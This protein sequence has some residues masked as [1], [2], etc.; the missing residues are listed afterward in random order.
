MSRMAILRRT[1]AR[2]FMASH[3]CT[4]LERRQA[5]AS[6]RPDGTFSYHIQFDSAR[7]IS[8]R[9]VCNLSKSR[10]F[11][12]ANFTFKSWS[13]PVRRVKNDDIKS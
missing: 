1:F 5:A 10:K 13:R 11:E 8:I 7:L 4:R 12:T 2:C 9:S 3:P 6:A